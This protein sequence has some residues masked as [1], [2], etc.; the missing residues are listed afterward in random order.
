MSPTKN[1]F[2]AGNALA[3]TQASSGAIIA[4]TISKSNS[5]EGGAQTSFAK[6]QATMGGVPGTSST[7]GGPVT[8]QS[9]GA[10]ASPFRDALKRGVVSGVGM[11]TF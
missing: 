7:T 6:T 10:G 4:G 8:R 1:S 5:V 3:G 11:L 9:G 2:N